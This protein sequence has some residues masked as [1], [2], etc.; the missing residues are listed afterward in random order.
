MKARVAILLAVALAV[1]GARPA[2]ATFH[3][4]QIEQVIGG[5]NGATNIQAV[6]LRL[7][8]LGQNLVSNARLVAWDA[9]GAN[10]VLLIAFPTNVANSLGG[11]RVLVATST[12]ANATTPALTPDFIFTNP[13]PASYLAAGSL[14]YEDNIGTVLWRLSWGGANYTGSGTG[15]LTNDADGNFDPAFAGPLPTA[16][17]QALLFK[18]SASAPSTNNA[19]DYALTAGAATFTNNARSSGAI[20][21]TAAVGSGIAEG[22]LVLGPPS[23][24]PARNSMVFNVVLPRP[25]RVQ[26]RILDLGGRVVSALADQTLPAGNHGFAWARGQTPLTSGVYFLEMIA[27]G[28]RRMQR[29]VV[30][31]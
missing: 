30:V 28:E 1:L 11:D 10:P 20:S 22:E 19:A 31:H 2:A 17:T 26:V 15:S 3:L 12:F 4:M 7:R 18:N 13:I 16:T 24:N 21:S 23:P 29:F 6:Q 9:T 27:G 8:L 14:T 25:A 5:V